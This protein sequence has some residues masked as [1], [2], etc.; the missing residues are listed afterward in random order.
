MGG[1]AAGARVRAWPEAKEG[2]CSG[3]GSGGATHLGWQSTPPRPPAPRR[4]AGARPRWAAW[5]RWQAAGE[6]R[7]SWLRAAVQWLA[8]A[9]D[10]AGAVQAA[11]RAGRGLPRGWCRHPSGPSLQGWQGRSGFEAQVADHDCNEMSQRNPSLVG[12]PLLAARSREHM[13]TLS[14]LAASQPA[15]TEPWQSQSPPERPCQQL[16]PPFTLLLTR[17]AAAGSR[18]AQAASG[19]RKGARSGSCGTAGPRPPAPHRRR[20]RGA[21]ASPA[22]P[23][24]RQQP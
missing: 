13:N 15:L 2:V 20:R 11:W 6:R 10:C 19:R 16:S 4:A 22:H 9:H 14:P 17:R 8:C 7:W 21:A 12:Q 24:R 23:L 5:R 1:R 3:R 18:L